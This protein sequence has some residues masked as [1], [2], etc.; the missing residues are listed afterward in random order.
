MSDYYI[1]PVY[2]ARVAHK[3]LIYRKF[4][5]F[6]NILLFAEL[7]ARAVDLLDMNLLR[8]IHSVVNMNEWKKKNEIDRQLSECDSTIDIKRS[9]ES[10]V[11]LLLFSLDFYLDSR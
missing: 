8:L 11:S 6:F 10:A 1:L 9:F 5:F 4:E 2:I 3:H 7:W